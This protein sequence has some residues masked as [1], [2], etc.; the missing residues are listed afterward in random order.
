MAS[1]TKPSEETVM[2]ASAKTE[3]KGV[4]V[5]KSV[6]KPGSPPALAPQAPAPARSWLKNLGR[7]G[8]FWGNME[9]YDIHLERRLPLVKPMLEVGRT[10][11]ALCVAIGRGGGQCRGPALC[12]DGDP[13]G[14]KR[15]AV[16]L[17]PELRPLSLFS[18][19]H[20]CLSTPDPTP[21]T[22]GD[23]PGR[24]SFRRRSQGR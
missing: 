24:P 13:V 22:A 1:I 9:W 19:Q 4:E 8:G 2:A 20:V 12:G 18:V 21:R 6:A 11:V 17:P 10:R 5:A 7:S 3:T 23:G 15:Q 16:C 14:S